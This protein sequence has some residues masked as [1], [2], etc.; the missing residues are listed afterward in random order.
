[1]KLS[2]VKITKTLYKFFYEGDEKYGEFYMEIKPDGTAEVFGKDND[3]T[4]TLTKAFHDAIFFDE[5]K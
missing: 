5:R 4:E 1:M 3:Y 2:Y